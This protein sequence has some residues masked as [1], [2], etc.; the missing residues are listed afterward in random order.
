MFFLILLI[1]NSWAIIHAEETVEE[2]SVEKGVERVEARFFSSPK[3]GGGNLTQGSLRY[4]WSPVYS[5]RLGFSY[6]TETFNV[7]YMDDTIVDSLGLVT[8]N[9]YR[10]DLVPWE[11]RRRTGRWSLGIN[12]TLETVNEYGFYR[13]ADTADLDGYFLSFEENRP[14]VHLTPRRLG[15]PENVRGC[16]PAE[17]V[18]GQSAFPG[19][20][21]RELPLR[22]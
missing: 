16:F 21:G 22:I 17:S 4:N 1:L 3:L 2:E 19:V 18:L 15:A 11:V 7:E 10:I 14:L 13:T 6:A 12:T 20:T 8:N 9:E 5:S